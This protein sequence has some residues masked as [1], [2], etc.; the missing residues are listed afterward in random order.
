MAGGGGQQGYCVSGREA[1]ERGGDRWKPTVRSAEEIIRVCR[2]AEGGGCIG[3]ITWMH[4]FSPT[5]M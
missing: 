3:V 2:E 5:R 1:R 4:T